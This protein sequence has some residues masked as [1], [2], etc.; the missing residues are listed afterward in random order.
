[1]PWFVCVCATGPTI[2]MAAMGRGTKCTF[3]RSARYTLVAIRWTKNYVT[4]GRTRRQ[5]DWAHASKWTL[6]VASRLGTFIFTFRRSSSLRTELVMNLTID[7]RLSLSLPIN[8]NT[9]FLCADG[10]RSPRRIHFH[11][12]VESKSDFECVQR[13]DVPNENS[14]SRDVYQSRTIYLPVDGAIPALKNYI[15][16]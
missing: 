10:T 12:M 11:A 7:G 6:G 13:D 8:L 1:M 5:S 16:L 14:Q 2:V 3:W 9:K 15:L 4:H